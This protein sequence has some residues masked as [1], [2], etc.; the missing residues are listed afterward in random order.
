M[1][2]W[3][4]LPLA[5]T[6][7]LAVLLLASGAM[8][9]VAT[10]ELTGRVQDESGD[11]LPGVT[12]TATSENL[13]GT[14]VVVADGNGNYKMPFL[15]AGSYTVTYELEGFATGVREVKINAG[16]ST[17]SDPVTMQLSAVEEEIVVTAEL[18]TISKSITGAAT[19]E[20]SEVEQLAVR[21][22]MREAA[23]LA[24]GVHTTALGTEEAPRVTIS[25]AMSF[26]NLFIMNGVVMNENVRGQAFDLFIE[27][28]IEETTVS[29]SGISAE[30]GRFTGGVV[31]AI[32]KSGGNQFEGSLRV[33]LENDDWRGSNPLSP[34]RKDDITETLEATLGGYVVKD[35]A[36]FFGAARDTESSENQQTRAVTNIPFDRTDT[37]ERME[38]K[39]TVS[40]HSS[41]SIIGSYFEIDEAQ[42]N[43][44]SFTFID[45]ASLNNR[46]LPQ[47]MLT[48]NYT[49]ILTSSFFVEAQ[50]SERE[51]LFEG[52][53][54]KTT[55]LLTGTLMRRNGT[56]H[57]WHSPT[58]CGAGPPR[59]PPE[60]RSNENILVKGSYF[61]STNAGTHDLVFGYDTFDDIRFTINRQTGSDYTVW[62]DDIV[63]D[64]NNNIFSVIPS[65]GASSIGYWAVFNEDLAQPNNFTTNSLYVNDSWQVN[66]KLSLNIGVRY[67]END[68][69]NGSGVT[70]ADDSKIS[71]RLGFNYD[72]RGD[73]DLT[74]HGG[75]ATYVAG[76]ANTQADQSSSG[77]AIGLFESEYHGPAI[78]TGDDCI[79]NFNCVSTEDALQIL[80]DWYFANGGLAT[81][82]GDISALLPLLLS[83]SIPGLNT[84]VPDTVKSPS[85]QEISFGVNKRLGTKG[86][87]RADLVLREWE[88]FYSNRT[89]T[90]LGTVSDPLGLVE[91]DLTHVG[92]F[93]DGLKREY[94]GLHT[95]F[96]YRFSDKFTFA[97]NYAWSELTGN[98]NGETSGSGPVSSAALEFYPEYIDAS[99][100]LSDGKLLDDQTHRL[101]VWGVYDIFDSES[102]SLSVSLLQNFFSGTPYGAGE[103]INTTSFVTNPGY[104]T[105]DNSRQYWFTARD[106]FRTDDILSTDIS[107]NYAFHWQAFG[108]EL[109]VF[110]QPEVTN[111]F[112]EDGVIDLFGRKDSNGVSTQRRTSSG[113]PGGCQLF[114]P[115]TTTPV[116]GTH[117]A[118]RDGFHDPQ[119]QDDFQ[120]PRTYRVSVGFRF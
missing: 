44:G 50:Y 15:P 32:S 65:G 66:D 108:S 25:G 78:N 89:D 69:Q 118:L 67:D 35:H 85:V 94:I 96:R 84:V 12:M 29:A 112:N 72:L 31:N 49:G 2:R 120:P 24:P 104:I 119:N 103:D 95:Q 6:A 9:Q 76:I 53:G 64:A 43:Q 92:N 37:E 14:R 41:H 116:E 17:R 109:E 98:F 93:D 81:P 87:F 68:G 4:G 110:V 62:A 75:F 57:R 114:N 101:R 86:L 91:L 60:E 70:V 19:V 18:E 59:C 63:V 21:R 80:F 48:A 58:F 82:D 56:S 102:Q 115:F 36:W 100:H 99:W 106:A 97:G 13:Q 3:R 47:E 26:E 90:T 71:P 1:L 10:G 52:S 73:G 83:I 105:P 45:L 88:D 42:N 8:A 54:S 77:G 107:L 38:I 20:Q 111:V 61:L 33:N 79:V 22:T 39:A 16:Q 40:P 11:P 51:F 7:A 34:E 74:L 5:W 27:D 23:M 46:T 117:W 28:A 113:C 55:D 30:Y